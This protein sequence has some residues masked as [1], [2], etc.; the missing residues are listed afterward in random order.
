MLLLT[1]DTVIRP[2]KLKFFLIFI[3]WIVVLEMVYLTEP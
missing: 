3:N 2:M 1:M